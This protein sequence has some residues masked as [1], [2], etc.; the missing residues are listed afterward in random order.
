M[1]FVVLNFKGHPSL[2]KCGVRHESDIYTYRIQKR[3]AYAEL[4]I[5]HF[6]GE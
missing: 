4:K 3:L 6:T 5:L 1:S 2:I